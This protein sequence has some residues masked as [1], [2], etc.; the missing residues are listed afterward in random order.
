MEALPADAPAFH[1]GESGSIP[2]PSL[3]WLIAGC[4]D[5]LFAER[6]DQLPT[7]QRPRAG[8]ENANGLL[9]WIDRHTLDALYFG[10]HVL[11]PLTARLIGNCW[12]FEREPAPVPHTG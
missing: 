2:H 1:A 4:F 11:H 3:H 5:S 12:R 8:K 7:C 9:R 6:V 10:N